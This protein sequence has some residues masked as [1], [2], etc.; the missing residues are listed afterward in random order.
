MPPD[1]FLD[2]F[3]HYSDYSQEFRPLFA[4]MLGGL[5]EPPDASL[6]LEEYEFSPRMESFNIQWTRVEEILNTY[7]FK[8][9]FGKIYVK[10]KALVL[11]NE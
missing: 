2:N 11:K 4:A 8:E 10:E 7:G 3:A 1:S 5:L 9:V 6:N